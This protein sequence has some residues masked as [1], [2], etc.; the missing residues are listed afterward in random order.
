M[1]MDA[2]REIWSPERGRKGVKGKKRGR[3]REWA[4]VGR[5]RFLP[6][7]GGPGEQEPGVS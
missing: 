5:E 6:R 1:P 2:R 4:R 7:L 3:Q